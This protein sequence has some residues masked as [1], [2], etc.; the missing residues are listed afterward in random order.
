MFPSRVPPLVYDVCSPAACVTT[1][2]QDRQP[3]CA[4]VLVCDRGNSQPD[5]APQGAAVVLQ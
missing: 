2:L 5:R 3:A 4:T 1:P